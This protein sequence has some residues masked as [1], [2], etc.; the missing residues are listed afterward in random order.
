MEQ[1]AGL[2][3]DIVC[4]KVPKLKGSTTAFNLLNDDLPNTCK[5]P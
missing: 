4:K 2:L 3:V 5:F 1:I